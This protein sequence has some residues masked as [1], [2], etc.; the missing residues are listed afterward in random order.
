MRQLRAS[1]S[2]F[3][4]LGVALCGA[5]S[6]PA[7]PDPDGPAPPDLAIDRPS[8]EVAPDAGQDAGADGP[9]RTCSGPGED[10]SR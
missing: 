5:C 4:A 6:E 2:L 1:A 9:A 10:T 3:G 8:L 7:A